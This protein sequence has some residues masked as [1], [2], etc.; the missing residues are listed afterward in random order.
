M[1]EILALNAALAMAE[2]L[3]PIIEARVKAGE[4]SVEEQAK[5]RAN[6]QALRKRGDEVFSGSHWKV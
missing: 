2:K 1:E 4:V 5:A 3:M 6:Y